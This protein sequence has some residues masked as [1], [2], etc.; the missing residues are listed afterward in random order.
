MNRQGPSP[1]DL[2]LPEPVDPA[3]LRARIEAGEWVV[4]LRERTAFAAGHLAGSLGFEL[5][6]DFVTYL[7]WLHTYRTPLT[8]IGQDENRSRPRDA[9]W[10]VSV[11]TTWPVPRSATSRTLADGAPLRSYRISDFAGLVRV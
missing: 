5:S 10:C 6:D 3:Q 1:V 2:S 4:D 7:G 8:L 9:S 11:S